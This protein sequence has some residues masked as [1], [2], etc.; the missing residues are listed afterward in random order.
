MAHRLQLWDYATR[1]RAA[2]DQELAAQKAYACFRLQGA[3]SGMR[4]AIREC[5]AVPDPASRLVSCPGGPPPEDIKKDDQQAAGGAVPLNHCYDGNTRHRYALQRVLEALS[6]AEPDMGFHR[7]F[8]GFCSLVLAVVDNEQMTFRLIRVVYRRLGLSDYYGTESKLGGGGAAGPGMGALRRDVCTTLECIERFWPE[9]R[10]AF[11]SLNLYTVLEGL[12]ERLLI[13]LLS[14]GLGGGMPLA[15]AAAVLDCIIMDPADGSDKRHILCWAVACVFASR[16]R[17][18]VRASVKGPH[19]LCSVAGSLASQL[20]V[21]GLYLDLVMTKVDI[22]ATHWIQLLAMLP[23]GA[24]IGGLSSILVAKKLLLVSQPAHSWEGM[25]SL[26]TGLVSVYMAYKEGVEQTSDTVRHTHEVLEDY[27]IPEGSLLKPPALFDVGEGAGGDGGG[28]GYGVAVGRHYAG[29]ADCAGGVASQRGSFQECHCSSPA[30]GSFL[31][32][33]ERGATRF[34]GDS[35]DD[36]AESDEEQWALELEQ[37]VA[38]SKHEAASS[39]ATSSAAEDFAEDAVAAAVAAAET[40]TPAA[41]ATLW[42]APEPAPPPSPSCPF[43]WLSM[44]PAP[45]GLPASPWDIPRPPG[46]HVPA[47][48]DAHFRQEPRAAFGAG[49]FSSDPALRLQ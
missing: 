33:T 24:A 43:G 16:D 19:V 14:D 29:S 45:P 35:D 28:R 10:E 32:F 21:D 6:V 47:A 34:L 18:L 41:T 42:R 26:C 11:A 40:Q 1:W 39:V 46:L 2:H 3:S 31:P 38:Q 48:V 7:D 22:K 30:A 25:A 4:E 5:L 20:P 44:L 49:R 17:S 12:V 9:V 37:L 23:F 13:T 36:L 27:H 15:D 8:V